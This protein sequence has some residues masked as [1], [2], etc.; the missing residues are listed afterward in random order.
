MQELYRENTEIATGDPAALVHPPLDNLALIW[1]IG[2][3]IGYA[4]L[5]TFIAWIGYRCFLVYGAYVAGNY[6]FIFNELQNDL[7]ISAGYFGV[8]LVLR[9]TGHL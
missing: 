2:I 6:P 1:S 3:G 7:L 8:A 5:I 4:F 9:K